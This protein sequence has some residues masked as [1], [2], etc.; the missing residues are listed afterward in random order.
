MKIVGKLKLQEF[1]QED[2]HKRARI[3]LER[4]VQITEKTGWHTFGQ[5]KQTFGRCSVVRENNR[6]FVVFDI[7][8]NKYRLVTTVNY[9]G[10]IVVIEVMLTHPEYDRGKWKD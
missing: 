1:W 7:G 2:K 8:G 3:P 4:W 10:Q 5:I 6:K 9:Q